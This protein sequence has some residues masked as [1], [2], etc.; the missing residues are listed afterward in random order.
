MRSYAGQQRNGVRGMTR[1]L[2]KLALTAGTIA[3]TGAFALSAAAGDR[4]SGAQSGHAGAVLLAEFHGEP[5]QQPDL[6]VAPEVPLVGAGRRHQRLRGAEGGRQHRRGQRGR[7]RQEERLP[8]Q[9]EPRRADHAVPDLGQQPGVPARP[10][11]GAPRCG[12]T[13]PRSSGSAA[14]AGRPDRRH[15]R[16]L[17]LEQHGCPT[18]YSLDQAAVGAGPQLRRRPAVPARPEPQRGVAA[19]DGPTLGERQHEAQRAGQPRRHGTMRLRRAS[20]G[21]SPAIRSRLGAGT[22][23]EVRHDPERRRRRSRRC[24]ADRRPRYAAT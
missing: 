13:T 15:E 22:A 21:C 6:G 1:G 5:V 12:R 8:D 11:A 24:T 19:D 17:A 9:H 10:M 23:G 16:R 7:L 3:L 20:P 14:A 2:R 4:R 18:V